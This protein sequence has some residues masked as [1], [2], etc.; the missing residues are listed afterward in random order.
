MKTLILTAD[1]DGYNPKLL[2]IIAQ[3]SY[4]GCVGIEN[5]QEGKV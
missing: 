5:K 1:V 3:A 2:N 4:A